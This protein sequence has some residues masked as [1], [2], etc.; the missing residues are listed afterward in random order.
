MANL[1]EILDG[2]I[3]DKEFREENLNDLDAIQNY[4]ESM[5]E[6]ISLEQAA[7]IQS[8]GKKWLEDQENGNGEYS[9]MRHE[10]ME[11]LD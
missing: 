7:R 10:A 11:S 8:A 1:F 9:R 2:I 4:A 3:A 5:G 6:N